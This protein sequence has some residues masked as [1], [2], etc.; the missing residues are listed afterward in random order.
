VRCA[1][2]VGLAAAVACSPPPP[3]PLLPRPAPPPP[4]AT[5]P[6]VSRIAIEVSHSPWGRGGSFAITRKDDAFATTEHDVPVAHVTALVAAFAHLH[7]TDGLESCTDH[8]DDYPYVHV[9]IERASGTVAV[10]STSNCALLVPWNVVING[11][12]YAQYDGTIGRAVEQ[13]L[14]DLEPQLHIFR[15]DHGRDANIYL[16]EIRPA[17]AGVATAPSIRDHLAAIVVA[18]P[19]FVA[20]FGKDARIFAS[21]FWCS[22]KDECRTRHAHLVVESDARTQTVEAELDGEIVTELLLRP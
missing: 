6:D 15:N 12:L 1:A 19:R 10:T 18:D 4:A 17:P 9:E 7:E 11:R 13:L 2:L 5:L 22:A 16:S 3:E 14:A 21:A 20:A 8:T